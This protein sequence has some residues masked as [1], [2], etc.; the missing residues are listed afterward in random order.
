M[1]KIIR[2]ISKKLYNKKC[3]LLWK[4]IFIGWTWWKTKSYKNFKVLKFWRKGV[5]GE[6]LNFF[7]HLIIKKFNVFKV[8]NFRCRSHVQEIILP[9]NMFSCPLNFI[10]GFF[11]I[12]CIF[13]YRPKYWYTI[14]YECEN[15]P[16]SHE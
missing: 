2:L 3:P 5:Q 8:S 14:M 16:L 10:W 11:G 13:N 15:S 7:Y 12:F 6:G 4:Y 9:K 1:Y